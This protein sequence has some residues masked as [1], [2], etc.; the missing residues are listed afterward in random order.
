MFLDMYSPVF[1]LI[2]HFVKTGENKVRRTI[3][4]S[5]MPKNSRL[6]EPVYVIDCYKQ[7]DFQNIEVQDFS[8]RYQIYFHGKQIIVS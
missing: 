2:P 8:F 6:K 1:A 4:L 5:I 3:Y 7:D